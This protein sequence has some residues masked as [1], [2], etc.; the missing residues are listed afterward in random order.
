V[1]HRLAFAAGFT[2]LVSA[3]GAEAGVF[4][5]RGANGETKIVNI[6]GIERTADVPQGSL[7]GRE[8]LWP[9]VEEV[10]RSQGVDPHLV[11]LIIR[12]ESGY[13]PHAV[14]SKGARGVMQLMPDTARR[15]GVDNAFNA[16]DNIRAGI[17]YFSELLERF[18]SDV[19]LA[20]A[21]YNAGPEA[22]SRY[23]GVPPYQ[24]TRN[25]VHSILSAYQGG[26][27]QV[28]SGGFGRP[29]RPRTVAVERTTNGPVISN[30][31][32]FGEANVGRRLT[33]R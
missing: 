11:D 9:T 3:A 17:S 30:T 25:Y 18:D 27:A 14:S 26:G 7:M 20:L 21:A 8:S 2:L 13:D 24:E 28:V 16:T 29:A 1:K 6:P 23:G 19:A 22:V 31:K 10:S 4:V 33:L 5:L 12:M 15:Y 32:R